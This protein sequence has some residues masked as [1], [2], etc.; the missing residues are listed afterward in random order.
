MNKVFVDT[1]ALVALFD[2]N[3][4]RH[5]EA[6]QRL[7]RIRSRRIGMVISDFV[8]GESITTTLARAGH[9]IAV[10]VGE[11]ILNSAI[12][13]FVWLDERIKRK[14]WEYFKKHDDKRFSF[15]DCT[16]FVL[17][18]E[19]NVKKYFAFDEDFKRAG[20]EEFS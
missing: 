12:V 1:S 4:T 10:T 15:T 17:M 3:D 19:I 18:K 16:S 5:K 13:D 7:E 8:F 6:M 9:R 14:A 11:Y 20:F 2:E